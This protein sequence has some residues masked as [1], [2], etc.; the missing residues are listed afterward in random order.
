MATYVLI[1]GAG[2]DSW[3]WHLVVPE[4]EARG[5]DVVAADLPCDDD[6]A[7]LS[8]YADV[9]STRSATGPT[10]SWSAQSLGGSPRPL[11]CDRVPVELLVLVAAMVPAAGRVARRLVGQH[12]LERGSAAARRDGRP[13]GDST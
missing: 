7:G 10:S 6:S 12:R 2:D 9:W 11:V 5:H 8:E 13:D 1:H 4:L 3:Y